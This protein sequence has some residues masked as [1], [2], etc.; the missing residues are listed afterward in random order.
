MSIK[1]VILDID[2]VLT[3]GTKMYD[4]NGKCFAK[5]FY[6]SDFTTIKRLKANG[7]NVCFLSGDKTINEDIA[8]NR[9]IDFY[10]CPKGRYKEE[11]LDFLSG[12][13]SV[14]STE[15]LYIGDDIFDIK[16]SMSVKFAFCPNNAAS[17]LKS[18]CGAD[19]ILSSKGGHGVIKELHDK[20]LARGLIKATTIDD[21]KIL[22][23]IET[24]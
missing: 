14:A 6:D 7:L 13:Y 9:T 11:F 21:I 19:N 10:H 18:V 12:H 15:M 5:K 22:D 23:E 24:W 17:D 20:L 16:I 4:I 8:K 1:L 3:D 2:G